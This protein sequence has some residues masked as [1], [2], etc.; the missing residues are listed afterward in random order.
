MLEY[1]TENKTNEKIA[2]E[3]RDYNSR[4][5]SHWQSDL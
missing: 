4:K 2:V 5:S 3:I 1:E